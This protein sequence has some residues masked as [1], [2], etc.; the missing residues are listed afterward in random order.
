MPLH[1]LIFIYCFLFVSSFFL[2]LCFHVYYLR[3]Y[4]EE[5]AK[6]QPWCMVDKSLY[7]FWLIPFFHVW[8]CASHLSSSSRT[9]VLELQ[10]WLICEVCE[11]FWAVDIFSAGTYH[12]RSAH[13]FLEK[14]QYIIRVVRICDCI[15][16]NNLRSEWLRT[17]P[18]L[19]SLTCQSSFICE[20]GQ[21][22]V[23]CPTSLSPPP[24]I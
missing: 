9:L 17:V 4:E 14:S 2:V 21:I 20:S 15:Y 1:I 18:T 23:S 6:L 12:W 3:Q 5:C 7:L 19:L 8:V 11:H 16:S 22:L 10:V 13:I 24:S